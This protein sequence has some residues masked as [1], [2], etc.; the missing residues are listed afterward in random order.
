MSAKLL[1]YLSANK[2]T[3]GNNNAEQVFGLLRV[4][5]IFARQLRTDSDFS[6]R[7]FGTILPSS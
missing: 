1:R 7:Y 2:H 4:F 6:G 5:L 3:N